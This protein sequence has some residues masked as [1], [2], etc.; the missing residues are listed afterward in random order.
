MNEPSSPESN[1]VGR[2]MPEPNNRE[3]SWPG[4]VIGCILLIAALI[5]FFWAF[6]LGHLS[7][8]QRS[9]LMWLLPLASG[10]GCGAFAGSLRVSGPVGSLAVAATGG[11]AVWLLSYYLLPKVT[12]PPSPQLKISSF[13][14]LDEREVQTDGE[15]R[16]MGSLKPRTSRGFEY[17]KPEDLLIPFAFYVSGVK[18]DGDRIDL[19]VRFSISDGTGKEIVS[20]DL[21]RYERFDAWK[22]RPGAAKLGSRA[23]LNFFDLRPEEVD[24]YGIV[25]YHNL[26]R[27]FGS[28]DIPKDTAIIR[29]HA[30]DGLS[31][32][33]AEREEDFTVEHK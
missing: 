30:S 16:V 18:R 7:P 5:A 13:Q 6:W 28:K 9:L 23:I 10:F 25:P 11:F 31:G 26:V 15:N 32:A 20:Q 12:E 33:T 29:I 24:K 17:S 2:N 14:F 8:D 3:V 21:P 1:S 4:F 19:A 27:D 22:S